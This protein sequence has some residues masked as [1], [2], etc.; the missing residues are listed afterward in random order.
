MGMGTAVELVAGVYMLAGVATASRCGQA[1]RRTGGSERVRAFAVR[2]CFRFDPSY[3]AEALNVLIDPR[4]DLSPL[5][6]V[7]AGFVAPCFVPG[8]LCYSR[9]P[10]RI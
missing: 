3:S 6:A 4:C 2:F 10:P 1:E 5:A 8:Q 7:V 9:P